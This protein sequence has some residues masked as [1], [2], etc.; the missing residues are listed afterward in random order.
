MHDDDDI[1]QAHEAEFDDA[2]S[3]GEAPARSSRGFWLVTGSLLLACVLL[4]LEIFANRSIGNDIGTA[5]HEL[6][7]AQAGAE[8][9]YTETGSF[10]GADAAG[11]TQGRY[12][13]G[14]LSYVD[15]NTA[16]TRVR[17]VSITATA[18]V[19]AAAVQI[20]PG[21]CFYLRLNAG[22]AD[23]LYGVGTDCTGTQALSSKD[24]QW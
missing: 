16:A 15:G 23:P 5:Q 4:L 24:G 18:S 1:L 7:V 21:A 19:W 6:R 2:V 8:R 11:L 17:A 3:D 12:D 10:E 22:A 9:V 13:G 20:K 14:E